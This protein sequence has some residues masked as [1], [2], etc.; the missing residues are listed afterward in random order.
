MGDIV[1]MLRAEASVYRDMA[2]DSHGT[3]PILEAGASEIESLRA[4]IA[5]VT[6]ERDAAQKT[7]EQLKEVRRIDAKTVARLRTYAE[8]KRLDYA[9][10]CK[11]NGESIARAEKA[12]R[13]RDARPDITPED[14]AAFSQYAY[15][16]TTPSGIREGFFHV[17]DAL[18]NH[19]AK[20]LTKRVE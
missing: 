15:E 9:R 11:L 13:E 6:E 8:E 1:E 2:G 18:R 14:A 10:V 5:R 4:E 19:A 3:I 12:E 20:A 17:N 16:P 7:I